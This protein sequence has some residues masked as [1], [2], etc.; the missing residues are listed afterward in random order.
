[1]ILAK[2]SDEFRKKIPVIADSLEQIAHIY[3]TIS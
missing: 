3:R 1:M 2:N